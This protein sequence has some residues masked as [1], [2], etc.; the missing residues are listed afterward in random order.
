MSD[1]HSHQKARRQREIEADEIRSGI[2]QE[3]AR[4]HRSAA[5]AKARSDMAAGSNA[6]QGSSQE[7]TN[8][9]SD[10]GTTEKDLEEVGTKMSTN[11]SGQ[12]GATAGDPSRQS[13]QSKKGRFGIYNTPNRT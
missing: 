9:G 2:E 12:S 13:E 6:Q 1:M 4:M 11:A 3:L 8:T 10:Q 7:H 5:R